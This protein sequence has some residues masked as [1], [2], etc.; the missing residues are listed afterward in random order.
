MAMLICVQLHAQSVQ[1]CPRCIKIGECFYKLFFVRGSDEISIKMSK[2]IDTVG[3][4]KKKC[5]ERAKLF[6]RL[7]P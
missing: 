3:K 2:M 6:E 7:W 4:K 5:L 1:R